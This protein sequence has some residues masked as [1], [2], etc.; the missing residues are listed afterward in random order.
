MGFD[1]GQL[2]SNERTRSARR[3]TIGAR[4]EA[5]LPGRRARRDSFTCTPTSRKTP[6]SSALSPADATSAEQTPTKSN[7]PS[8]KSAIQVEQEKQE[9]SV[10]VKFGAGAPSLYIVMSPAEVEGGASCAIGAKLDGLLP[11]VVDRVPAF[12]HDHV[13]VGDILVEVNGRDVQAMP[14]LQTI[15]LFNN[16]D[17]VQRVSANHPEPPS[18]PMVAEMDPQQILLAEIPVSATGGDGG[19]TGGWRK[20]GHPSPWRPGYRAGQ[21]GEQ[22]PGAGGASLMEDRPMTQGVSTPSRT[23]WSAS[24][25]KKAQREDS[26]F[27]GSV[28][29]RLR[30]SMSP[31]GIGFSTRSS[32]RVPTP[33]ER[34]INA[35][36]P[37][38]PP[39]GLP[40]VVELPQT[41]RAPWAG[42]AP[43]V[44]PCGDG[45]GCSFMLGDGE[46]E[47]GDGDRSSG[48]GGGRATEAE[49]R[50]GVLVQSARG[51]VQGPLTVIPAPLTTLRFAS[52]RSLPLCLKGVE[53]CEN[54]NEG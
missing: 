10:T 11:T 37:Q 54:G 43:T 36:P 33:R 32:P 52:K 18:L 50:K 26:G 19:K 49:G 15:G 23:V 24:V 48:S 20:G 29:S 7:V 14:F 44:S 28:P 21:G 47:S 22:Q 42:M 39:V 6:I 1:A 2:S 41:V 17:E 51:H 4:I 30:S 45:E 25:K 13:R 27:W 35:S 8:D 40:V 3:R 53:G 5:K 31:R 34:E 38:A 12:L 16:L 46:G 9:K